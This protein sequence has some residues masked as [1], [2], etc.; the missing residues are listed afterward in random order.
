MNSKHTYI[1]AEV[2]PN[3]NG[4]LDMALRMVEALAPIDVDAIKF[5]LGD[6]DQ[7]YSLDA[8]KADYQ[9][10]TG[11]GES[12]R[13]MARR[14]QLTRDQH[15]AVAK[16]CRNAGVS[17]LCTAF[18]LDSL[19]FLDREIGLEKFKIPSGEIHTVDM[20]EYIAGRDL[21]ILLSTGMA[22][23]NDIERAL[24]Y[25]RGDITILHCVSNYPAP[26]T[27]MHLNLIPA[28]ARRFGRPV[29]FSDHSQ[30]N[31]C[32]IAAVALGASVVEKH[33]TLDRTL[34]GPDHQASATIDEF[35]QLVK[36]IRTVEAALGGAE[37]VLSDGE[38]N[39]RNV[40]RKSIVATRDLEAGET[41]KR[42]DLCFKRPGTGISPM[43][44][45]SVLGR[46]LIRRVERDRLIRSDDLDS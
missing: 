46:T 3:H 2:G 41:L 4:S 42:G 10:R 5:Q 36:S 34:P 15:V 30:G 40:A 14:H 1:I 28:I 38:K 37:K 17:Y 7:V 23:F 11:K 39:V 31:D 25:L 6:P 24:A 33:V 27:D 32:A 19:H 22:S 21:P 29:G 20:L 13:D 26:A 16:A 18:D 8:F 44:T 43:E 35:A 12:P 45:A 9:L